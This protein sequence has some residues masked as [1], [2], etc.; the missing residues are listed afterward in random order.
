MCWHGST[1]DG[2]L[3]K[4]EWKAFIDWMDE[5]GLSWIGWS[6][7][8]KKETCSVLERSASPYGDWKEEEIKVWGKLVR[9][10]LSNYLKK[11]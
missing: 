8:D 1:G 2:P 4:N 6:V 9:L 3:E 5:K 7:F 10:F 11:Q